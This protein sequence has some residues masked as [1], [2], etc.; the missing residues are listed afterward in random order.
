MM[1]SVTPRILIAEDDDLAAV[2]FKRALEQIGECEIASESGEI[3]KKLT[4]FKPHVILL[5]LILEGDSKYIP[6]EAGLQILKLLNEDKYRCSDCSIIVI[7]GRIEPEIEQACRNLGV[8]YYLK[9]PIPIGELRKAVTRS[10][11]DIFKLDR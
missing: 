1:A 2:K 9:K 6:S 11:P 4:H 8:N 5:D 3:L 10:L 7:T